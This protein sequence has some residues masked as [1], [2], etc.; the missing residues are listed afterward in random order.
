ML[1]ALG[2]LGR[3]GVETKNIIGSI[4]H[5]G[6]SGEDRLA[7]HSGGSGLDAIGWDATGGSMMGAGAV[8]LVDFESVQDI[9]FFQL[10]GSRGGLRRR[11]PH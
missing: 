4:S 6:L 10:A 3:R 5:E 2:P 11:G 7:H 8:V 9:D 1:F